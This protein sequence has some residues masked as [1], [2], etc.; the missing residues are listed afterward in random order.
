M[1][2]ALRL[3][4][5]LWPD[6]LTSHLTRLDLA[7]THWVARRLGIY[8]GLHDWLHGMCPCQVEL[9]PD[10]LDPDELEDAA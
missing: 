8:E 4:G 9:D 7:Q 3:V 1:R 10:E 2:R 5:L 6:L